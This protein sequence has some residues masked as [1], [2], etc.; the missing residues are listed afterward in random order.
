MTELEIKQAD[1]NNNG[2]LRLMGEMGG[3]GETQNM[4]HVPLWVCE[5]ACGRWWWVSL[6]FWF[7]SLWKYMK[8]ETQ[9]MAW[10]VDLWNSSYMSRIDKYYS[11]H[12]WN[13]TNLSDLNVLFFYFW[14]YSVWSHKT[15][16]FGKST[17]S[18]VGLAFSWS[19]KV[20]LSVSLTSNHSWKRDQNNGESAIR[21]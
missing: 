8:Y 13:F 14:F 12:I 10:C 20:H 5:R 3:R 1:I 15:E 19:I 18:L 4:Y 6:A 2:N 11:V 9:V 21:L 16:L 7:F 17:K